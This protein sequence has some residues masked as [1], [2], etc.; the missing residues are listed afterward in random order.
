MRGFGLD[1]F[2]KGIASLAPEAADNEM[3]PH[4]LNFFLHLPAPQVIQQV[5]FDKECGERT[6]SIGQDAH[7]AKEEKNGKNTAVP[8]KLVRLPVTHRGQGY[9]R[10]IKGVEKIPSLE[11]HIARNAGHQNGDQHR[12]RKEKALPERLHFR[13]YSLPS[14]QMRTNSKRYYHMPDPLA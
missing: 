10:H 11:G 3:I 14:S 2:F 13:L 8:G 7:S 5:A 6:H 4:P 1:E 9:D 12:E